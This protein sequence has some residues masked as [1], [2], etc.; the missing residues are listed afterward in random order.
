MKI[1]NRKP[2]DKRAFQCPQCNKMR[3]VRDL[4]HEVSTVKQDYKTRDGSTISLIVD[5]CDY[6][7]HRNQKK[8]FEPT[9]ADLRRAIKAMHTKAELSEEE[10]LEDLL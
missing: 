2:V 6:C 9:R 4:D 1:P 7:Q 3:M 5:I 8:Y 10:T